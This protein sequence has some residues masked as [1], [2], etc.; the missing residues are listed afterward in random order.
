M[1][2][3]SLCAIASSIALSSSVLGM[4]EVG[5]PI[6]SD[7]IWDLAG[8]PY[9]VT[10]SVVVGFDSTLTIEPGVEVRVS[11]GL[12]IQVGSDGF[13][14]GA[15][16]ARG[17]AVDPIL[18]TSNVSD[19][20][21][22]Q[23]GDWND[24]LFSV[25]AID[26]VF[27]ENDVYVSG[28]FIEHCVIE[29][30]GGG[31][32]TTGTITIDNSTPY[33]R[34]VEIRDSSRTGIRGRDL[35]AAERL[36]I[37]DCEIHDCETSGQ[38][39][40]AIYI[41]GGNNH[42]LEGL[43][44]YNNQTTQQG[45][46][47]YI[48]NATG[49]SFTN[50]TLNGNSTSSNGGGFYGTNLPNF[51]A[52]NINLL[53]NSSSSYG[54][55]YADGNG[56]QL[57]DL[58]ITGNTANSDFGGMLV[59]SPNG[60]IQDSTITDNVAN[61]Q[62]GGVGLQG[63]GIT[64]D[65]CV[66]SNNI[67]NRQGGGLWVSASSAEISNC[68]VTNN[69]NV[70]SNGTGGGLYHN[71]GNSTTYLNTVIS[72]NSS[73]Q[74]GGGVYLNGGTGTTF[75]NCEINNNLTAVNGGG[76]YVNTSSGGTSFQTSTIAGNEAD[77]NGGGFYWLATGGSLAGDIGTDQYTIVAN[78]EALIAPSIYYNVGQGNDLQAQWVCWG[79]IDAGEVVASIYDFFD[80]STRGFVLFNPLVDDPECAE[81]LSSCLGDFDLD[82]VV[83]IVDLLDFL[84]AWGGANPTFDIAP[85][86]GDG[87]VDII[88]L[89]ALLGAWG[90]C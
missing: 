13:G 31:N 36:R 25:E 16:V 86:G 46:G 15:L 20:D 80:D 38:Q 60:L 89:L 52:T 43:T 77:G 1:N 7:T 83:G 9:I 14:A 57:T 62:A 3:N 54:G 35:T 37:E 5:G 12:G 50:S 21:V 78:N 67:S 69:Q 47:I 28:S 56:H 18:I 81:G 24:I 71:S 2:R 39:G 6:F 30:A 85:A 29:Y 90:P 32:N 45:G 68:M 11:P 72:N 87:V 44:I 55:L 17:T 27:D 70:N 22:P 64:M 4:T 26:A 82:G 59:N 51:V 73:A 88:D 34:D 79:T 41:I 58:T 42:V 63:T 66:I 61:D 74:H 49:V 76:V 48:Q 10:S 40:A 53:N 65:N 33:F 75:T 19:P 8:S 84:A 23:P